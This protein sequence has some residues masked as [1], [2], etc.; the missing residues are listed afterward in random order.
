MLNGFTFGFSLYVS[1]KFVELTP[2]MKK[3][4]RSAEHN[5]DISFTNSIK[6]H[7]ENFRIQNYQILGLEICHNGK[8]IQSFIR[9][10]NKIV[11]IIGSERYGVS[12]E[13]LSQTHQNLH[14]PMFGNNSSL[15]VV[16]ATGMALFQIIIKD[17]R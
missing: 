4:S 14:I 16:V 17:F 13:L 15:N 7:L 1:D 8:Q 10:S 2:K 3:T 11:L 12:E 9:F 5:L 6:D